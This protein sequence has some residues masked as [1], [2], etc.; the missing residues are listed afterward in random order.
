MLKKEIFLRVLVYLISTLSFC[1]HATTAGNDL[2]FNNLEAKKQTWLRL[3]EELL[4][5][6]EKDSLELEDLKRKNSLLNIEF[7]AKREYLRILSKEYLNGNI[8]S[9]EVDQS[10]K[11]SSDYQKI[12][13]QLSVELLMESIQR[14]K[15]SNISEIKI[16]MKKYDRLY[17]KGSIPLFRLSG[18]EIDRE[19]PTL[20]KGGFHRGTKSVFMDITRTSNKEWLFILMHELYHALDEKM[21]TSSQEFSNEDLFKS[22]V[23]ISARKQNLVELNS[24]EDTLLE[25]WVLAGLNRGLFA[26]YRAWNF[27]FSVY[28]KGIDEGLWRK[29]PFV[30]DVLS[31]KDKNESMSSF[32]YRYL[33]E[34]SKL[35]T[36]GILGRPI[37]QEKIKE[38]RDE[39]RFSF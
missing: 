20:E 38:K 12:M 28:Q 9:S 21:A 22:I 25:E 5:Y 30:E 39:F 8:D 18:S 29:V 11:T 17:E 37:I 23:S 33:N 35:S 19:S 24:K 14:L 3:H 26:E 4:G 13:S 31:F 34:R 2:A 16:F 15:A 36:E 1:V 7:D 27:G 6:E 32:V 10:F